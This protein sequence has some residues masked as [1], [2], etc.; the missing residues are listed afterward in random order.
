MLVAMKTL[1]RIAIR[2]F[3]ALLIALATCEIGLRFVIASRPAAA[4]NAPHGNMQMEARLS[5]TMPQ[6]AHSPYWSREFVEALGTVLD[7]RYFND[8]MQYEIYDLA[9]PGYT[10]RNSIRHTT[11]QPVIYS[12][13]VWLFGSS[14][15]WG[16]FVDDGHT[17]ASYL[18][19]DIP[20]VRV[21][22]V[23]QPSLDITL[24]RY[25][26]ERSAVQPGDVVVFIDGI[27]DLEDMLRTAVKGWHSA[28]LSC[29]IGERFGLVVAQALC[30]TQTSGAIPEGFIQQAKAV[31]FERYWSNTA[32]AQA[33]SEK[34]GATFY[35]FMQPIPP[36]QFHYSYLDLYP[37]MFR[38]DSV[39][40]ISAAD[41]F[42]EM[43]YDD[44]GHAAIAAQ[45]AAVIAAF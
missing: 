26:L 13:T 22:N 21:V 28:T 14:S 29:Q 4:A 27:V 34:R 23:G 40:T 36:L 6:Y 10:I 5:G 20:N 43:H 8:D 38:S 15:V 18:Q 35:H 7:Q 39:L 32:R 42:D 3:I 31:E 37:E 9:L 44:D 17:I 41:F 12:R 1:R 24:E 16:A 30:M 11:D 19:R 2:L 45:I 33:F 25:W